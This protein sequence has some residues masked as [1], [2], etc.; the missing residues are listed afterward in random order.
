MN[1]RSQQNYNDQLHIFLLYH[2]IKAT[3][4]QACRNELTHAVEHPGSIVRGS[5][6]QED[7]DPVIRRIFPEN[8]AHTS[9]LEHGNNGKIQRVV[10]ANKGFQNNYQRCK[11]RVLAITQQNRRNIHQPSGFFQKNL[12]VQCCIRNISTEARPQCQRQNQNNGR[13]VV[14]ASDCSSQQTLLLFGK[15]IHQD[16]SGNKQPDQ[17]LKL[18]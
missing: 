11:A 4:N 9:H 17:F 7:A 12:S 10:V 14:P 18:F 15:C 13:K 5:H 6:E 16:T 2:Q 8:I 1:Q 3:E